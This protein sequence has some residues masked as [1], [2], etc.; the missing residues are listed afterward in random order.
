MVELWLVVDQETWKKGDFTDDNANALTGTIYTDAD[1]ATVFNMTAYTLSS[2]KLFNQRNENIFTED[3]STKLQIV[4]AG[5]GTWRF[6]PADGDW[7][8]DFIGE[9]K[10]IIEKTGTELTAEGVN[11]SAIL[12]IRD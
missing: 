6:K 10:I 2:I 3:D 5:S 1:L 8:I 9:V 4:S 12:R 7:N 11:G